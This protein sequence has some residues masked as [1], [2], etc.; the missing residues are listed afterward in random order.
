M[1]TL[2][3]AMQSSGAS[4]F[5]YWL[6]QQPKCIG[7]IDLYNSQVAP[8]IDH[9]N[10]IIKCTISKHIKID[11]H[12]QNFKPDKTIL[13]IRNPIENHL[14]LS[15]K[16]YCLEGGSIEE[17][18]AILEQNISSNKFDMIIKYEDFIMKNIQIGDPSY[19]NFER[20]L[21][22]IKSYNEINSE[23]C[24]HNHKKK[25]GYGNIHANN[26][27]IINCIQ[28]P[29]LYQFYKDPINI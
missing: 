7:I 22:E 21:N 4:L 9:E 19:Y 14:S 27:K 29:D 12:K 1:K 24:K 13:F 23:W 17:K 28:F 8:A 26:L 18:F 2:I 5:A 25:W 15:E 6:A 3:Y 10:V 11:E 20:T 16:H